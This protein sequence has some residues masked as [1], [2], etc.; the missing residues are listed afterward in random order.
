MNKV[1]QLKSKV[2][3]FF[4]ALGFI[5]CCMIMLESFS[6]GRN[7]LSST[8]DSYDSLK[9]TIETNKNI[10]ANTYLIGL[11]VYKKTME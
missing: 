7:E 1:H 2:K 10:I 4:L 5:V 8:K 6:Q 11:S 3:A 9:N